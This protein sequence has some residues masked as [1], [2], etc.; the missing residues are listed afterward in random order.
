VDLTLVAGLRGTSLAA[1]G[2]EEI[3]SVVRDVTERKR[4]EQELRESKERFRPIACQPAFR[5]VL[6]SG[7]DTVRT[8][9]PTRNPL[10]EIR[11]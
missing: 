1:S 10:G 8:L 9:H 6:F 2:P 4:V 5:D 11:H 3:L 7:L